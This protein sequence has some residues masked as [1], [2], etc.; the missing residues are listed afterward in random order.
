MDW[1]SLRAEICIRASAETWLINP[2]PGGKTAL[3]PA[4]KQTNELIMA[5]KKN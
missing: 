1:N 4:S 3:I 5:G 2:V